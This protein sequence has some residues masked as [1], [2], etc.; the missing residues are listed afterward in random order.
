MIV[1]LGFG[2]PADVA[3]VAA[4]ARVS[5]RITLT[6]EAGSFGGVPASPPNFGNT[7]NADA[8]IDHGAMFDFYDG[9]GLDIA[10]LGLAQTDRAGNINVSKFGQRLTG[11]GGF[12]NITQNSKKVVFMG[13]FT[14]GADV[15]IEDGKVRIVKEG[16]HKKFVENVE[17][18][19]FSGRYAA[20]TNQPV[21]YIT[22][23]AVFTLQNGTVTLTELAPG[24]DLERDVL[25]QM[26][27]VPR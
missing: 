15:R 13:S 21:Y 5:D 6:T 1:N 3:A 18:I 26:D 16:Q 19:T 25:A 24:I 2:M 9:G 4:E 27:F 11:P 8:M 23:R 22:E 17:H 7:Y 10:F 14:A 20:Q 12:I